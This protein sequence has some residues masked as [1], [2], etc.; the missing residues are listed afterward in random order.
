[1]P[2]EQPAVLIVATAR[3]RA[4]EHVDL[5]AAVELGGELRRGGAG[6]ENPD[7]CCLTCDLHRKPTD[8]RWCGESFYSEP[9][10]PACSITLPQR[11][12]S[13]STKRCS[14]SG[15]GETTGWRR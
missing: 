15:G 11:K 1:M 13:L 10:R 4:D 2:P 8:A 12:V 5:L 14:S 6:I 9:A 7:Q 3:R